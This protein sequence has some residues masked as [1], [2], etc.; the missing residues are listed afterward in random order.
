MENIG[1]FNEHTCVPER[2]GTFRPAE[3]SQGV[4]VSKFIQ[5]G[6][7]SFVASDI[8]FLFSN[9]GQCNRSVKPNN[10]ILEFGLME[11]Q[12]DIVHRQ[13]GVGIGSVD[14]DHL[15]ERKNRLR[16]KEKLRELFHRGIRFGRQMVRNQPVDRITG[17][18]RIFLPGPSEESHK[19][20]NQFHSYNYSYVT[21]VVKEATNG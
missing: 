8:F 17:S 3:V 14:P 6:F 1:I 7:H 2:C 21:G 20:E 4:G 16:I 15:G 13:E 19:K 5:K 11:K 10:D 12:G 9:L 18:H